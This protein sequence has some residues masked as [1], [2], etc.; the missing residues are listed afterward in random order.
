MYRK[1]F[2][3]ACLVALLL[4]ATIA[5][6]PLAA[7]G[8]R[9]AATSTARTVF[10]ADSEGFFRAIDEAAP[11]LGSEDLIFEHS[12][13]RDLGSGGRIGAAVTRIQVVKAELEG[14]GALAILDQT[15]ILSDGRIEISGAFH[16]GIWQGGGGL[17]WRGA[18]SIVGGTGAFAG[19][20]GYA[21]AHA[22][23]VGGAFGTVLTLHLLEA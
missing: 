19:A 15:L 22:G 17:G 10:V 23:Q 1:A 6:T 20:R 2:G 12:P 21:T 9:T 16:T 13:V 4:G 14:D 8:Q 3:V 5:V 7:E 11:G 18:F